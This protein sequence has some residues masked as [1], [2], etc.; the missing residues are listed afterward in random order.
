MCV[1]G[2]SDVIPAKQTQIKL[3]K[4]LYTYCNFSFAISL[5]MFSLYIK[6]GEHF[7]HHFQ[8]HAD[9]LIKTIAN[10]IMKLL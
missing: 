7:T 6:N 9:N 10:S 4:L 8:Q 5:L 2:M 1:G 3:V